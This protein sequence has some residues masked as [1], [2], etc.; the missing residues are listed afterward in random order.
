MRD[1]DKPWVEVDGDT[2]T[3]FDPGHRGDLACRVTMERDPKTGIMTV[4]KIETWRRDEK[5]LDSLL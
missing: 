4:T 3:G 2:V 5:V 1:V